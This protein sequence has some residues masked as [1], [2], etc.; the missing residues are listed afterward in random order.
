MN[1]R[2]TT[3]IAQRLDRLL[4][5][6]VGPVHAHRFGH[7]GVSDGDAGAPM[8]DVLEAV[9][10]RAREVHQ[11]LSHD[12][13]VF[14]VELMGATGSGKT[15]LV[16]RV[17]E[18]LPASERTAV[19]AGDVAGADDAERYRES[20]VP[21]VDVTTGKD[22]H[23]D[24]ERVETALADLPVAELDTLFV[25]NVGNM[26]CP[27]DFP[28][29]T[30]C[31]VVVVSVTEGEDVVRK[32]PLLFQAADLAVIN[33]VDIADAV[34]TDVDRMV[35]DL[36]EVAPSIPVVR[37]SARTRAGIERLV[38]ELDAHRTDSHAHEHE[39]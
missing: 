4:A 17:V 9:R 16:Q 34:G 36:A 39:H 21:A 6:G 13:D 22:C 2:H 19:V 11:R 15:A 30:H 26:V 28:L 20:G 35:A 14:A 25:E 10:D 29:G 18:R 5:R 7:D 23:L 24:P 38:G 33:K 32:H 27:A 12:N 31:R 3:S 1:D 37:T 8:G